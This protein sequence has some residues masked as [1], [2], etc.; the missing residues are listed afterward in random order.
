[1]GFTYGS[2][3]SAWHHTNCRIV[4]RLLPDVI[5]IPKKRRG[6]K[7]K[8]IRERRQ[9]RDK[10]NE[11]D[12]RDEINKLQEMIQYKLVTQQR[13][14]PTGSIEVHFNSNLPV[15]ASIGSF[16]LDHF[17]IRRYTDDASRIIFEGFNPPGSE[18]PY[19]LTP[20]YASNKL[21]KSVD[22]Y[23]SDLTQKGLL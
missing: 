8:E 15:S 1:M 10:R 4:P 18:G 7:R 6:E 14:S 21:N 5:V 13:L 12:E 2:V 19:I 16:N 17:L 11:R 20:E 9:E 3:S 23:I 22:E